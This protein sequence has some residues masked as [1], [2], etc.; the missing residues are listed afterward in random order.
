MTTKP[1]ATKPGP[2]KR[3]QHHIWCNYYMGPVE[4]CPM[5]P[6]LWELYPYDTPE[7]AS[8]LHEKHFSEIIK[9]N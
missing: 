4:G 1:A 7:E 5:C 3:T 6:R 2:S 9:V 8:T